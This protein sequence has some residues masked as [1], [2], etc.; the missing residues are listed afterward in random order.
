MKRFIKQLLRNGEGDGFGCRGAVFY[1]KPAADAFYKEGI[2]R[3]Q[4]QNVGRRAKLGTYIVYYNPYIHNKV[5]YYDDPAETDSPEI[6]Y[7]LKDMKYND[8]IEFPK[9]PERE[10][11]IFTGWKAD[12][13]VNGGGYTGRPFSNPQPLSAD[14]NLYYYASWCKEDEYIPLKIEISSDGEIIKGK[15]DGEKLI[16]K[17]NFGIFDEE[18]FPLS[19]QEEYN[20]AET[21]DEKEEILS[22]WKLYWDVSGN[23]DVIIKSVNKIDD[24]TMEITLS[25]N[26]K[27]IYKNSE[28]NIEFNSS[29]LN[30]RKLTEDGEELYAEDEVIKMDKDG[31]KMKMYPSD[32]SITLK[33]QKKPSR[34]GSLR[35]VAVSTGEDEVIE[36]IKPSEGDSVDSNE[37][38][39]NEDDE[40]EEIS[41]TKDAVT[42]ENTDTITDDTD[43]NNSVI[44]TIGSKT[45]NVFGEEKENDVEPVIRNGRTMLPARFV[46]EALGAEV[47]WNENERTVTVTKD[48]IK[49]VITID[50]EIAVVNGEEIKLD[51]PAFIESGRTYTPLRLIA[52]ALGAE[53]EWNE[54]TQTVAIKK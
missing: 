5:F 32:N 54:S 51:S 31:V 20:S 39:G 24:K 8:I 12:Y 42:D 3:I 47:D 44:F 11:Y 35:P 23:D 27:D 53:V 1:R 41:D 52:E 25:G 2:G 30:W 22:F 19:W 18:R 26:S 21:D 45:V 34:G 36:D 29:C 37:T 46:A 43:E 4:L 7:E 33:A 48:D 17:T 10:G 40:T 14:E 13:S 15:E 49:I 9:I 38:V 6:Y 50:S 28:I 16:L